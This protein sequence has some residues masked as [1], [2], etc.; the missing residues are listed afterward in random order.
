LNAL[1]RNKVSDLIKFRLYP[2]KFLKDGR[3]SSTSSFKKIIKTFYGTSIL[4]QIGQSNK[5]ELIEKLYKLP[6]ITVAAVPANPLMIKG[7]IVLEISVEAVIT[8]M[9]ER[10]NFFYLME[11]ETISHKANIKTPNF[12][13]KILQKI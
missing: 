5:F 3:K 6:K 7:S 4:D 1:N 12:T 2:Y 8:Y 9:L 11:N 10:I 13:T